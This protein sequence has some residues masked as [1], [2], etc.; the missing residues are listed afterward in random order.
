MAMSDA[1]NTAQAYLD[2]GNLPSA[3]R[4]IEE[5]LARN[6]D[7]FEASVLLV[8]LENQ[9]NGPQAVLDLTARFIPRWPDE[10]SF[11]TKRLSA[12]AELELKDEMRDELARFRAQFMYY[13][14]AYEFW[15][16]VFEIRFGSEVHA[17]NHLANIR[18]RGDPAG[19]STALESMIAVR[20]ADF[21]TNERIVRA[22]LSEGRTDAATIADLSLSEFFNLKIRAARRTAK[23]A[24]AQD[25]REATAKAVL[26]LSRL[27]WF[28]PFFFAQLCMLPGDADRSGQ[29]PLMR[30]LLGGLDFWLIVLLLGAISTFA[31]LPSLW[32]A[33]AIIMLFVG[34]M[35]WTRIV[36]AVLNFYGRRAKQVRHVDLRDF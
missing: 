2:A 15:C 29:S 26:V 6:P 13:P 25:P 5:A 36:N 10:I 12:L 19:F 35:S 32:T 11:R 9:E 31:F 24:L 30:V 17:A 27:V 20:N 4:L 7:S 18:K 28:P 22:W 23:A 16:G 33:V 34:W 14:Q 3:R 1:L 21:I 8:A